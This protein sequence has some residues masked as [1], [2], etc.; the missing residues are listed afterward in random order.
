MSQ[1]TA[2]NASMLSSRIIKH[3]NCHIKLKPICVD[4]T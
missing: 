1:Y 3:Y 4:V 2:M